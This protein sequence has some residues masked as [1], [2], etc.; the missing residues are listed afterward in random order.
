MVEPISLAVSPVERWPD[1][2]L[3]AAF[4]LLSRRIAVVLAQPE[5]HPDRGRLA[6]YREVCEAAGME[7]V[8]RGI[9]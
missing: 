9:A 7:M 3:Q 4:S 1:E 8:R 6:T 5:D 2:R